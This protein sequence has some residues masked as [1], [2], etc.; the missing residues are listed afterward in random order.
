LLVVLDADV[1]IA[2]TLANAGVCCDIVDAWLEGD[3]EVAAC[4]HL[5]REIQKTLK[6]PRIAGRYGLDSR[7]IDSWIQRLKSDATMRPDPVHPP[8]VVPDDPGDDYLV[9]LAAAAG[10]TTLVSRDRHLAKVRAPRGLRILSPL[11][12]H[13]ELASG[14][15]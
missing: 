3:F 7:D 2:G 4:P 13:R 9:A 14:K 12:F 11:A 1:V 5:M 15:N 6:H 10:A 8:R